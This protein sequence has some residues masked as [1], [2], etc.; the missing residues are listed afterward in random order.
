MGLHNKHSR[1]LITGPQKGVIELGLSS[2]LLM[3]NRKNYH[4]I[5]DFEEILRGKN[6]QI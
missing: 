4:A 2:I 5:E 6:T 3:H 1:N